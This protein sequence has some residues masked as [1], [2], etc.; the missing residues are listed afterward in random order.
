M[1]Y[2]AYFQ[3]AAFRP[4]DQIVKDRIIDFDRED[5]NAQM[6]LVLALTY[7]RKY[8]CC[9]GEHTVEDQGSLRKHRE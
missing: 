3:A 9:K 5:C 8:L 6:T 2:T 7:G 1:Y 4:A